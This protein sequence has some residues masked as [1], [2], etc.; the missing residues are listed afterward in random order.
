M[1]TDAMQQPWLRRSG[2][3]QPE[4][5]AT[6]GKDGTRQ[7]QCYSWCLSVPSS[8]LPASGGAPLPATVQRASTGS[9]AQGPA[10]ASACSS[11]PAFRSF[12]PKRHLDFEVEPSAPS[13]VFKRIAENSHSAKSFV[14]T[15]VAEELCH[16]KKAFKLWRSREEAL[17]GSS[18]PVQPRD[19][20][21][22]SS[23]GT[24]AWPRAAP[25]KATGRV[26]TKSNLTSGD[27]FYRI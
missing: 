26:E 2:N 7:M 5:S 8:L 14:P 25:D 24:S 17:P 4:R 19:Q 9:G 18:L 12:A 27:R 1:L 21:W 3:L 10:S 22:Y 23:P 16:S 11:F 6:G 20:V 13:L 15:S